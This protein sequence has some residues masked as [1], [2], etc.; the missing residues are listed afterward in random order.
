MAERFPSKAVQ[1][2]ERRS[3]YGYRQ[4]KAWRVGSERIGLPEFAHTYAHFR[5]HIAPV[6]KLLGSLSRSL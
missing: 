5:L 2:E 3:L 4:G 6:R 1:A